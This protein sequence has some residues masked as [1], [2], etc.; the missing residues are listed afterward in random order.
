M[1]PQYRTYQ[2]FSLFSSRFS[3]N[4]PDVAQRNKLA[5]LAYTYVAFMLDYFTGRL[6]VI[7]FC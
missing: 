4:F 2:K 1:S 3:H 7:S 5:S 6:V